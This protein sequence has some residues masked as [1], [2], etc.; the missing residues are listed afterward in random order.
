MQLYAT[1]TVVALQRV[2][3]DF[4]GLRLHNRLALIVPDAAFCKDFEQLLQDALNDAFHDVRFHLINAEEASAC[5]LGTA[6]E[7]GV[8]T[9]VL[10]TVEQFDGLERLIVIAIGLDAPIDY[11][12]GTLKTR[13]RLYRAL[14]R[15]HMMA[16]VVN[17]KLPGGWLEFLGNVKFDG[18]DASAYDAEAQESMQTNAAAVITARGLDICDEVQKAAIQRQLSLAPL[19][20]AAIVRQVQTDTTGDATIATKITT[21]LDLCKQKLPAIEAQLQAALAASSYCSEALPQELQPAVM[22]A[23]LDGEEVAAAVQKVVVHAEEEAVA[24]A[25]A[26]T[27][28]VLKRAQADQAVTKSDQEPPRQQQDATTPAAQVAAPTRARAT[29]DTHVA[30]PEK[31]KQTQAVWDTSNVSGSSELVVDGYGFDPY[32]RTSPSSAEAAAALVAALEAH[33]PDAKVLPLITKETAAEKD[34]VSLHS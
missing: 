3:R 9:L 33:A 34:Q 10:D 18:L 32:A 24:Q 13:S 11:S 21:A 8:E 14:T 23:V 28:A 4:P 2:N 19:V 25:E 30:A 26:A 29:G 27:R 17:E 15:A 5:V 6:A 7:P 1:H 31:E 20:H 16:L 12:E 22:L